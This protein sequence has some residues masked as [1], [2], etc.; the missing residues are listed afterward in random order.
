MEAEEEIKE[1]E[2]K[3]SPKFQDSYNSSEFE[4]GISPSSDLGI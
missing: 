1:N 4:L 3:E 2:K